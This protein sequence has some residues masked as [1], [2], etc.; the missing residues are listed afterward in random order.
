[1]NPKIETELIEFKEEIEEKFLASE[2][3]KMFSFPRVENPLN[4]TET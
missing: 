2:V 1:M 4:T 3:N